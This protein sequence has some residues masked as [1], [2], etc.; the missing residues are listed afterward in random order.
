[1]GEFQMNKG[2]E[3]ISKAFL[4]FLREYG[5]VAQITVR[6]WPQQS[7]VAERANRTLKEHTTSMLEQ[8]GLPD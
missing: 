4:P 2:G 3:Y 7:G 1:M 6:N 8:A 5:I